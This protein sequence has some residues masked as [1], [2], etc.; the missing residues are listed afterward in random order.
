MVQV[1]AETEPRIGSV[2]KASSHLCLVT[3]ENRIEV[4]GSDSPDY[5]TWVRKVPT[6]GAGADDRRDQERKIL[7]SDLTDPLIHVT[8]AQLLA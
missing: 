2:D 3:L 7:S 6:G 1:I 5:A 4:C 8:L